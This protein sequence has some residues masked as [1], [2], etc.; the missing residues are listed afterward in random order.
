MAEKKKNEDIKRTKS[1]RNRSLKRC[2][3]EESKIS[4]EGESDHKYM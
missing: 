4:E 3:V 1:V 2:L